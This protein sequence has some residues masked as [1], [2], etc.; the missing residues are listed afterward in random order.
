[1]SVA[2][3][4]AGKGVLV[5]RPLEQAGSLMLRLQQMSA[6]PM[7]FPALAIDGPSQ[8]E[9][10]KARLATVAQYD[11]LIFVSPIAAQFGMAALNLA[12]PGAA[13]RIKAAAVGSGT[14][15]AL[16]AAGCREVIAPETGAD[17]EHLLALPE[18]ADLAGRQVLILRGED[19]R[20]L[21][22]DHLRA[23]GAA[24]DYAACYRRLCPNT[25]P[26][27]LLQALAQQ[28]LQA[29]TVF[30]RE[31]LDNL[32]QL[33]GSESVQLLR[34]LPLF[35]PHRRIAEHA[36]SLNFARAIATGPGESGLLAGL[37]EYFRHD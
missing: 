18:F 25:D 26:A 14:A 3:P 34:E 37:V 6:V 1:M 33:I 11:W 16:R 24:V 17:S 4:L 30:S 9:M 7:A 20:E 19:G 36:Q 28:R 12:A 31:T 2:G 15:D 35:A 22:A 32:L 23:R 5:T 29:L 13:K 27:P 8:P 21:I 10:L